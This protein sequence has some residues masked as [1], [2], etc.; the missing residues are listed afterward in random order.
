MNPHFERARVL[1]TQH[2]PE[3]AELELRRALVDEP[4][5]PIYQ[6]ILSLCLR[7]L[8]K[9]A[10]ALKE[11]RNAVAN[12][13]D[14]PLAHY[15]HACAL[16]AVDEFPAAL[17]AV[18]EAIRL[19]PEDADFH[20]LRASLF[21]Q[22]EN[23]DGALHAADEGLAHDPANADC[24][25]MRSRA[26]LLLGRKSEAAS[27]AQH[28]LEQDPDNANSHAS[29]G[30]IRLQQSRYDEATEHFAEALRRQPG[31]EWAR[32]GMLESL[33]AR[34]ILYRPI[35]HYF[36]W[37]ER[38]GPRMRWGLILGVILAIR[39][40]REVSPWL[41]VPLLAFVYLTWTAKPLFNLLLRLDKFGRLVLTRDE[42]RATSLIAVLL[43]AAV[44]S[45]VAAAATRDQNLSD[46][47]TLTGTVGSLIAGLAHGQ[48]P[49]LALGVLFA[50]M[51]MPVAGTYDAK[52][53]RKRTILGVYTIGLF[54]APP[55][56]IALA[57]LGLSGGATAL[58]GAFV[59]GFIA[60]LWIA[61]A[62]F[63]KDEP[64]E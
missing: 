11:A 9:H 19:D 34:R 1:L 58:V 60:F 62:E 24:A 26:L 10:A 39:L 48:T 37:A 12:G 46:S 4:D 31:M 29:A 61:Q 27:A 21:L 25:T 13:P 15:A 5:Q 23:P 54:L 8:R 49:F 59:I 35:L 20:A 36:L 64:I 43:L 41:V 56:A 52:W 44:A 16:D 17:D 6:A 2:R 45:F 7:D 63:G 47:A 14:L 57:L 3:Q 51:V 38:A 32:L 30:W 33:K 50:A 55:L 28:A 40:A 22:M 18:A 42:R 53:R